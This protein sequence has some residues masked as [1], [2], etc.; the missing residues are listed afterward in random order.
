MP[1]VEDAGREM[2][3]VDQDVENKC[4]VADEAARQSIVAADKSREVARLVTV[5]V[6]K[7]KEAAGLVMEA[8]EKADMAAQL[9]CKARERYGCVAR[10]FDRAEEEVNHSL[11]NLKSSMGG[12]LQATGASMKWHKRQGRERERIILCQP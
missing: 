4:I 2:L 11:Q 3:A 12:T 5:A 1:D 9:L 7:T 6:E 10:V 8:A